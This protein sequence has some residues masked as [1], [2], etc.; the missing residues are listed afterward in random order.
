[1]GGGIELNH[2]QTLKLMG[3]VR[4]MFPDALGVRIMAPHYL[5]KFEINNKDYKFHWFE[6][7][8]TSLAERIFMYID[9]KGEVSEFIESIFY[10]Y[11][12]NK[13]HPIEYLFQ[14]FKDI[15]K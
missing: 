11:Y 8:V 3:M 1:M 2:E 13:I 7:T 4:K 12:I 10:N 6:F 9:A 15:K 5:L 14:E